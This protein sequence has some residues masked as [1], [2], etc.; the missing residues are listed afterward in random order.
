M[1]YFHLVAIKAVL[2]LAV[3]A[4]VTAKKE[5]PREDPEALVGFGLTAKNLVVVYHGFTPTPSRLRPPWLPLVSKTSLRFRFLTWSCI[6][7]F[8]FCTEVLTVV[9]RCVLS[10]ETAVTW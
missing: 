4:P 5:Q 1:I 8:F 3:G 9:I 10:S 2:D 6:F 7:F